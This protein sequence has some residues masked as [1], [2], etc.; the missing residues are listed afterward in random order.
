[1]DAEFDLVDDQLVL[2]TSD[3]GSELIRL[4]PRPVADFYQDVVGAVARLG[5][6]LTISVVPSEVTDPIPFPDD[7]THRAYDHRQVNRFF[8]ILS[9]VDTVF[10]EHRTHFLGRSTPVQFFWGGFDLALTRFSGRPATPP[11]NS[12]IIYRRG[13]DAEQVCA[14]FWPGNELFREPAFFAYAYPKP[15]GI[16]SMPIRPDDAGWDEQLGEFIL[17][18][19]A[20]RVAADPREPIRDF[21]DST[22]RVCAAAAAWRADLIP[23]DEPR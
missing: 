13:G 19:D 10:K 23:K 1:M 21:L 6:D 16:E 17:P 20:A 9:K 14:G 18:Y 2:R 11:P 4:H 8:Q 22:Y 7:R 3:G 15:D 5:I 12:G